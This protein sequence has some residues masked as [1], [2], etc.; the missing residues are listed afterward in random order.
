MKERIKTILFALL[1]LSL[2]ACG[3]VLMLTIP[4]T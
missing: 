3:I 2:F 1:I 4:Q